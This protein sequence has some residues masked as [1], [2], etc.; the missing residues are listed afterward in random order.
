MAVKRS[1]MSEERKAAY[2]KLKKAIAEIREE[3][4][5]VERHDARR[6]DIRAALGLSN[7]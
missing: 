7:G 1:L 3:K 5:R 2:E 6:K 4:Q